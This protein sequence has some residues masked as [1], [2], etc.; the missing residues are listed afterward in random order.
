M[1][2]KAHPSERTRAS[3]DL[4]YSISRELSAQLDLHAL[5]NRI[6]EL[7]VETIGGFSG[8][9]LVLDE[10]GS[11]TEGALVYGGKVIESAADQMADTYEQG[12]AGWVVKNRHAAYVP[13]TREDPRWLQRVLEIEQGV[14]KSAIS[15]PLIARNRVVGV[16]TLVHPDEGHFTTDDLDLL[17]AIAEQAGVAVENARLFAAEQQRRQFALTLQEIARSINSTLHPSKV[18]PMILE[19]LKRVVDYDSASIFVIEAGELHLVAALGFSD[20]S[21]LKTIRLPADGTHLMGQVLAT[22]E[23]RVVNDVQAEKDWLPL[24]GPDEMLCIRSW[25]GA[26]LL[27]QD[28]AV[29]VLNVDCHN[30][31]SYGPTQVELVTAFAHQAATAVANARLYADSQRQTASMVSLAETARVITASL[32]LDDVL[33]R[34][35]SQTI[36][37]LHMEAASI[38]LLDQSQGTLEFV[39][40]DGEGSQSMLGIRLQKG[41]GIAGWVVEHGEPVVVEDVASD[42]RFYA[43]VDEQ[44]GFETRGILCVPIRV[45]E[46]LIG[47][48]EAINPAQGRIEEHHLEVLM[49]IAGLAGTAIQHA[50]LFSETRTARQRYAGLFEDSFDP[51]LIT[52]LSGVIVEANQRA[53]SFLG[54]DL[55][56]LEGEDIHSYHVPNHAERIPNLGGMEPGSAGSYEGIAQHADGSE[57]P[58]EVHVKRIDLGPQ[59]VLQ[60]ILRD[61]SERQALDQLRTDLTSMIFHDLRSPLGNV[62]SSLEVMKASLAMD[63][64]MAPVL[65][66]AQRSSRRLN[67][68]IESLLDLDHLEAGHDVLEKAP[69]SIS[70]IIADAIEEVRPVADAK[71]HTLDW[72]EVER[73]LPWIV[74]DEG[75]VRRVVINLVENAVKY[76]PGGGAIMLSAH[77]EINHIKVGIADTGPGIAKRDHQRIFDKFARVDRSGR[78]KGLGLGLAFCRLAIEAHQG[79]IWVESETGRGSAFYFT[80]PL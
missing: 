66:V 50:R 56:A 39:A 2:S 54:R 74:C 42:P 68:L 37:A 12:L 30:P 7:T 21:M 44:I 58:I 47:V 78:V 62:I 1:K 32:D 48:L 40:A 8:S 77:K 63:E 51:I 79:E 43:Q 59:P 24:S 60:W 36:H 33:Q 22:G 5:L 38:A 19:Q 65:S 70:E 69:A 14:S 55:A 71:G 76:T 16:L 61:I 49:G 13:S 11:L 20:D 29:G 17:T 26:P 41:Q 64:E 25:I 18:F 3:L 45:Q 46:E 9:I 15:V 6:L 4:L 57:L 72:S 23:P 53:Q 35:L 73:D 10:N 28:R 75:M 67:R 52:D 80:L 34:I 27:V 31:D